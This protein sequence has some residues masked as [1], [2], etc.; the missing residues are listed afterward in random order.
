MS[1]N[2]RDVLKFPSDSYQLYAISGVC[3]ND[4]GIFWF[5]SGNSLKHL[6]LVE[7]IK[8]KSTDDH[9]VEDDSEREPVNGTV[10]VFTVYDL[11]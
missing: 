4:F 10:V 11:R 3:M 5:L 1:I 6:F 7:A 9:L 8:R 2:G